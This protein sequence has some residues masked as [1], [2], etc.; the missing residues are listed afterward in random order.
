MTAETRY[1]VAQ[2]ATDKLVSDLLKTRAKL[3]E[4]RKRI[5]KLENDL[6]AIRTERHLEWALGGKV[7][8]A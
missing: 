6:H 1:A 5:K 3:R 7:G 2:G 8:A 4:A